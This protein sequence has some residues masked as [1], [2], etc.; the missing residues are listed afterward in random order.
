M[1]EGSMSALSTP[2]SCG[3]KDTL[4]CA[5]HTYLFEAQAAQCVHCSKLTACPEG[6]ST[7]RGGFSTE[8]ATEM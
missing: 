3:D 7:S 8:S 1:F 4:V 2:L 5:E 6:S